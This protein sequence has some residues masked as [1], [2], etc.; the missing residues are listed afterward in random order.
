MRCP[1]HAGNN[2]QAFSLRG[3]YFR[4]FTCGAHGD[5]VALSQALHGL[6]WHEAVAHIAQMA[7]LDPGAVPRLDPAVLAQR[8]ADSRRRQAAQRRRGDRLTGLAKSYHSLTAAAEQ[9]GR[10]LRAHPD[11]DDTWALLDALTTRRDS[12]EATEASLKGQ[13]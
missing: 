3:L 10:A 5:V 6:S 1:I 13:R 7:G 4:C 9:A 8:Q 2:R 11:D 12:I